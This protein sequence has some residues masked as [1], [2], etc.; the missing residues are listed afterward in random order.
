MLDNAFRGDKRYW[1]LIGFWMLVIVVGLVAYRS[2][3]VEGLTVTG[4]SRDVSWGIYISQF[5]FLVGVAA[6][7]VMVVLPYYLHDAKAFG[8]MVILGEFLAVAAVCVLPD[9]LVRFVVMLMT[10]CVYRL[11]VRGL[12]NI[13]VEGGAVLVSNHVTYADA[14]LIGATTQHV[15]VAN[16][17]PLS[18][19]I[20]V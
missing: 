18:S 2:Q 15:S 11:T 19:M 8:R 16:L 7:A 9:F 6:S 3:L 10:R 13:P 4:M 17:A 14:V 5:T 12:E 1:A 20:W